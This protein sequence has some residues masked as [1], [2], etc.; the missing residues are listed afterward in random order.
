MRWGIQCVGTEGSEEGI[1][2]AKQ[3]FPD[4]DIRHHKLSEL[5]PFSDLS[6]QTVVLHQVIEHLE[7]SVVEVTMKECFRVLRPGGMIL[8]L[9][10]SKANKKELL[11]D[12]THINLLSPTDLRLELSKCGFENVVPFDSPLNLFGKS[13]IGR[14]I[15]LVVFK[16]LKIDA[17]SATA[18]A[19]AYK[20]KTTN[21]AC[22]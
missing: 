22:H 4:A 10:P 14:G 17:L 16:L 13:W 3:R 8:V 18:S 21:T 19:F 7:Q 12:P 2:I 11:A 20:Q 9:S 1:R 15:M 6:F 5:L